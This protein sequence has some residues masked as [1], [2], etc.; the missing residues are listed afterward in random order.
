MEKE[1]V[2]EFLRFLQSMASVKQNI[3]WGTK[4]RDEHVD[5]DAFEKEL[6]SFKDTVAEQWQ[7][8]YGSFDVG[9]FEMFGT[10]TDGAT[11]LSELIGVIKFRVIDFKHKCDGDGEECVLVDECVKFLKSCNRYIYLGN[12][13]F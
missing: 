6:A 5:A 9:D 11:T 12:M 1:S 13:T 8:I 2:L 3:H 4:N 7:G 10:D